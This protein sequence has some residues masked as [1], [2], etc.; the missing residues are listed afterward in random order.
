MFQLIKYVIQAVQK[1][2]DFKF[3]DAEEEK[4]EDAP[5][6]PWKL[7]KKLEKKLREV[8]NKPA[9]RY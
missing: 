4:E 8:Y 3:S 6:D 2:E 5:E 9:Y 7:R 1:L